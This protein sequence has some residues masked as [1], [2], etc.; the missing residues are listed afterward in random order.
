MILSDRIN[1]MVR[2]ILLILFILSKT[3]YPC[4]IRARCVHGNNADILQHSR[5]ISTTTTM[6]R[7][8]SPS[9]TAQAKLLSLSSFIP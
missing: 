4:F 8:R 5:T 6:L 1:R 3:L 2:I 7:M 9:L